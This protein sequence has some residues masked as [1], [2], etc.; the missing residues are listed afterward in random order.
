MFDELEFAVLFAASSRRRV[1]RARSEYWPLGYFSKYAL[2]SSASVLSRIDSQYVRSLAADSSGLD[3]LSF[4]GAVERVV[5]AGFRG[6]IFGV[7]VVF[8]LVVFFGVGVGFATT[9]PPL[10]CGVSADGLDEGII[11]S[12][13]I[14]IAKRP[15]KNRV[16]NLDPFVFMSCSLNARANYH[17]LLFALHL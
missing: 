10:P 9:S 12:K 1:F 2:K 3:L 15:V 16:P 6:V 17:P 8:V 11:R 7:E 4:A 14:E 13:A 5:F